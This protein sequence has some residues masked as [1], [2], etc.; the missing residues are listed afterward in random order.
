MHPVEALPA[1]DAPLESVERAC[2][3]DRGEDVVGYVGGLQTGAAR[4]RRAERD[5]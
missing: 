5:A 3:T 4:D 2:V 1:R